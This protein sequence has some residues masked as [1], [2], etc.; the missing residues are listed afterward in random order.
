MRLCFKATGEREIQIELKYK[1]KWNDITQ[2]L[3][4]NKWIVWFDQTDT[5][6]ILVGIISTS[7]ISLSFIFAHAG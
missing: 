1:D 4:N 2:N 5:L 3:L 6:K 7:S